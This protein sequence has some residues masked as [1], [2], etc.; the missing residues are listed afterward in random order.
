[1]LPTD[2]AVHTS[3]EG[4]PCPERIAVDTTSAIAALEPSDRDHAEASSFLRGL[5]NARALL[6]FN[7]L[8]ELQLHDAELTRGR[9]AARPETSD[10][11]VSDPDP[12]RHLVAVPPAEDD[13]FD[14]GRGL[15]R[16]ARMVHVEL[17]Y[18][19]VDAWPHMQRAGIDSAQAVH[20]AMVQEVGAAGLAT[21]DP[22]FGSVDEVVLPLFV[23]SRVAAVA[24]DRRP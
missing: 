24:R 15:S 16:M 7:D 6:F 2:R 3:T 14:R 12:G 20:V 11:P 19:V 5:A 4:G 8:V 10:R 22:S 17:P 13:L 9:S 1:M 21:T 18:L 23:P